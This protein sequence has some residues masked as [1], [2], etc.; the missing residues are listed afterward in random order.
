M[1]SIE[2]ALK[3]MMDAHKGQKKKTDK[4]PFILHPIQVALKVAQGGFGDTEIAAAL[5][6]D[7][8]EDTNFPKSKLRK[9]LGADVT[10]IVT[11]LTKDKTLKYKE[12]KNKLIKNISNGDAGVRIVAIADKIVGLSS[13]IEQVSHKGAR[14]WKDFDHSRDEKIWFHSNL[15]NIF[16]NWKH[17]FVGEYRSLINK[18]KQL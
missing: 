13:V 18:I 3:I 15:L 10:N 16:K 7:V 6:H 9:E 4:Q 17:P 8:L 1:N 14:G 5:V 2:K 11:S 12:Q